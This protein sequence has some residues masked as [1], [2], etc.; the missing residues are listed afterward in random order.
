MEPTRTPDELRQRI[1]EF[2]RLRRMV[3][4]E[5]ALKAL[6]NLISEDQEHLRQ[7]ECPATPRPFGTENYWRTRA[8]EARAR[9]ESTTDG[10]SRRVLAEVVE[11]YEEL[12]RITAAIRSRA[13]LISG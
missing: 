6:D 7:L 2:L 3:T 9:M 5:R 10:E 12:A 1:G 11:N 4:D 8:E 13:R